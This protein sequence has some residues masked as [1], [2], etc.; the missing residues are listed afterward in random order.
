MT[1]YTGFDLECRLNDYKEYKT[2]YKFCTDP[3]SKENWKSLMIRERELIKE[4]V[5]NLFGEDYK[6]SLTS[7]MCR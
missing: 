6:D 2:C 7:A 1:K 5:I 4:I 3:E